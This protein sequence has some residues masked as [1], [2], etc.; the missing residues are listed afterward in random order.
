MLY[1]FLAN[2]FEEIEAIAPMDIICRA[3]IPL[4]T[5][6]IGGR[7]VVGAHGIPVGADISDSELGEITDM[8]GVILPGGMPGT[9]NL[10]KSQTVQNCITL[11]AEK[12]L[13]LAAICAA[14]SILGRRGLLEG[15]EATCFDGY[16]DFLTGATLSDKLC[17]TSGSFITAAGAGAALDFGFEIVKYFKG[18]AVSDHLRKAM[19]CP[20]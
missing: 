6:G 2:G 17:V 4:T 10:E 8:T 12:G 16:E 11:A 9:L 20:V 18:A 13:L 3:E 7:A 15:K 1:M 5:V 14:P 19:K